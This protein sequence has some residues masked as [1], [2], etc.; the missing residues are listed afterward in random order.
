[1]LQGTTSLTELKRVVDLQ[2][3]RH[4][5]HASNPT[6]PPDNPPSRKN[7]SQDNLFQSHVVA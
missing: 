3:G 7:D 1:V 2:A 4:L 6:P 5:S